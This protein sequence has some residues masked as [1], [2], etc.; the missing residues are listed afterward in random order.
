MTQGFWNRRRIAEKEKDETKSE[1]LI[2]V[3]EMMSLLQLLQPLSWLVNVFSALMFFLFLVLLDF[4]C[5][6]FFS[7]L[8]FQLQQPSQECLLGLCCGRWRWV[9][10]VAKRFLLI[11]DPL[12][13]LCA[14]IFVCNLQVALAYCIFQVTNLEGISDMG[15]LILD[16]GTMEAQY[17]HSVHNLIGLALQGHFVGTWN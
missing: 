12:I 2:T 14:S 5:F 15:S 4:Y 7:L 9:C 3:V 6:F 13:L 1:S 8:N 17:L 16:S 11:L 10:E